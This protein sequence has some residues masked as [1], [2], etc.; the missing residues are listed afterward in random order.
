MR[1]STWTNIGQDVASCRDM[2]QVLHAS[3][4]D[5]TVE[6]RPIFTEAAGTAKYGVEDFDTVKEMGAEQ[7]V[8]GIHVRFLPESSSL[9][10]I[11][12]KEMKKRCSLQLR[13]VVTIT[14]TGSGKNLKRNHV[15]T[16]IEEYTEAAPVT[17]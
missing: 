2:E 13:N 8:E 1:T 17:P 6:K 7:L 10:N 5:Y 16:P 9:D 12:S 15:Y 4:L 14:T 11:T 3:G